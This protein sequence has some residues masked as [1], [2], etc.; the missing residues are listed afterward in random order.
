MLSAVFVVPVAGGVTLVTVVGQTLGLG[1][2]QGAEAFAKLPTV[3]AALSA[4]TGLA[5]AAHGWLNAPPSRAAQVSPTNSVAQDRRS[6]VAG[7]VLAGAVFGVLVMY[8]L[9][10][11]LVA[12]G[13]LFHWVSGWPG[14]P[15]DAGF[16][17][18]TRAEWH[19]TGH[20]FGA[21]TLGMALWLLPGTLFAMFVVLTRAWPRFIVAR[22]WLAL[23]G[24]LPWRLL[25][26]LADARQRDIL[27]QSGGTFQFRHIRLQE[28]LAGQQARG[29]SPRA[30]RRT[31]PESVRRRVVLAAGLAA[32]CAGTGVVL[33]HHQDQSSAVF[34]DPDGRSMSAVAFRP[35]THELVWAAGDGRTWWGNALSGGRLL[36]DP[37][38]LVRPGWKEDPPTSIPWRSTPQAGGSWLSGAVRR[39]S[40]GT[41][42]N[43]IR[44]CWAAG[45]WE[46]SAVSSSTPR[47]ATS[48]AAT[49]PPTPTR[50]ATS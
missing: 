49:R 36:V 20:D 31:D 8:G 24:Q 37:G 19:R 39:W 25:A 7:A 45:R 33:A 29:R 21:G 43:S 11:G 3:C 18:Y 15:G 22:W 27:R 42:G 9:R 26:F 6:A 1:T 16:G 17:D 44:P 10:T 41:S 12:G 14:W 30:S 23:R 38:R 2:L 32:A 28:A 4:V 50:T 47:A 34:A 40:S 35:G 13:L 5:L 48:L 46:V